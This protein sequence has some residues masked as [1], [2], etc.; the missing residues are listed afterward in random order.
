MHP[1]TWATWEGP[2]T[3]VQA[4]VL[5]VLPPIQFV[6]RAAGLRHMKPLAQG[7]HGSVFT[8]LLDLKVQD[9][10]KTRNVI[11]KLMAVGSREKFESKEDRKRRWRTPTNSAYMDAFVG[12]LASCVAEENVGSHVGS[13]FGMQYATLLGSYQFSA[14]LHSSAEPVVAVLYDEVKGPSLHSLIVEALSPPLSAVRLG[15]VLHLV[16]QAAQALHDLHTLVGAVHN[17]VHLGNFL[18]DT[19]CASWSQCPRLVLTDFGRACMG[20]RIVASELQ[21]G[22]PTWTPD[23]PAADM[24]MLASVLVA[25]QP[26]PDAWRQAGVWLQ[27]QQP[28]TKKTRALARALQH[29]GGT[30]LPKSLTCAVDK[31]ETLFPPPMYSKYSACRDEI[32]QAATATPVAI[33]TCSHRLLEELRDPAK[34]CGSV[35]P[36][37]WIEDIVLTA[38]FS[39]A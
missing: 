7:S 31:S 27:Q 6:L 14:K 38:P 36:K 25:V 17:D 9:E 29:F 39:F 32:E 21:E 35:L 19:Q 8:G 28:N 5:Q 10:G 2:L 22:F 30:V 1:D 3:P 23:S 37:A 24:A 34:G 12:G 33:A 13:H 18:V 20:P 11:I 15:V 26:V 16:L 4:Q